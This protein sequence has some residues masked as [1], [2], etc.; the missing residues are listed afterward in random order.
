VLTFLEAQGI[1]KLVGKKDRPR[2]VDQEV[3]I[4]EEGELPVLYRSC[5]LYHRTLYDFLLMTGFRE[6]GAMYVTWTDVHVKTNTVDMRWKPQFNWTPKVYKEREYRYRIG[7]W[8]CWTSI[9]RHYQRREPKLKPS[10]S[11]RLAASPTLT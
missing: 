1:S 7:C 8:R 2:F 4:Y 5:S 9:E 11:V 6:Q 3:E 10:Y